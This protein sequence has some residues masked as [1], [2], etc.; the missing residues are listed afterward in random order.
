MK[1]G[2]G[3]FGRSFPLTL[4]AASSVGGDI[5][6]VNLLNVLRRDHEVHLVGRNQCDGPLEN[7]VNH[8]DEG[9]PFHGIPLVKDSER[10]PDNPAYLRFVT[11]LDTAIDALP[12]LDAYVFWLGQHGSICSFIPSVQNEGELTCPLMSQINYCLPIVQLLNRRNIR[13]IWLCPDPRNLLKAR[14]VSNP[15]QRP[16]LAQYNQ[17]RSNL[18]YDPV[19]G[20]ARKDVR[21]NYSG[22][23]LLAVPRVDAPG[24]LHWGQRTSFGVLVNEGRPNLGGKGRKELLKKWVLN[25]GIEADVIG[26]WSDKA[27]AELGRVINP[28]PVTQVEATLGR[29]RSTITFPANAG[30]WATAK[31]WECFS[32][33]TVCFKHPDYDSQNHIFSYSRMPKELRSFLALSVTSQLPDRIKELEDY[34]TYQDVVAAQ[35]EYLTKSRAELRDGAGAV[36]DALQAIETEGR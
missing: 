29:W 14:D 6:V 31:P 35:F 23:E 30:G 36:L 5:E 4:D 16:V 10:Q 25:P 12:E 20:L 11:S 33:G 2:Y 17:S 22:I 15:N 19:N 28:V 26:H 13:P 21:Y 32:A 18:F 34:K 27:Q 24:G 1:I 8:W 7:V 9:G 3:K